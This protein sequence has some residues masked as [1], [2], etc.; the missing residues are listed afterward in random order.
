MIDDIDS[1]DAHVTLTECNKEDGDKSG[2]RGRHYVSDEQC[3]QE[4]YNIRI[5][6]RLMQ[7]DLGE[8]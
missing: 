1:D 6:C 7:R 3:I 2:N 4:T 5:V 8:R